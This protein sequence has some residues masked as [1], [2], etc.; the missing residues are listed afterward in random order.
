[1]QPRPTRPWANKA[2]RTA[3]CCI[4]AVSPSS[5]CAQRAPAAALLLCGG[6][7][8][9]PPSYVSR[10]ATHYRRLLPGWPCAWLPRSAPP[11][12]CAAAAAYPR[13]VAHATI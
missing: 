1:M 10:P 7:Q 4:L 2:L 12:L 6:L 13:R 9:H 3:S 8:P 5:H 11:V